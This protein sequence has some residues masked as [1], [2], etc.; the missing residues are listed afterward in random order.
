M[1]KIEQR[2]QR[3]I[4][5]V[6]LLKQMLRVSKDAM[7]NLDNLQNHLDTKKKLEEKF[8]EDILSLSKTL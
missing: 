8:L 4:E 2:V 3:Y 7:T 1:N 5:D 6:E